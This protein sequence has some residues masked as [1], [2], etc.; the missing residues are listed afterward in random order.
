MRTI[1]KSKIKAGGYLIRGT[2]TVKDYEDAGFVLHRVFAD[3]KAIKD[4]KC[5]TP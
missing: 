4:V 2:A 3:I 1:S 5:A